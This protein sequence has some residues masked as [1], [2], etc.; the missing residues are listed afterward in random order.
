MSEL[1][2]LSLL[3]SLIFSEI[4]GLSPGGVIVPF[5]FVLYLDDPV[6]L[7]ATVLSALG[8]LCA[9]K[10]LS[11][12]TILYG[13]RRFAVYLLVGLL[14]K[15]LFT[16]VYFGNSY[17]FYHLSMTIG[18][19]VPGILGREMERQGIWKTLAALASVVLAARLLQI[20]LGQVAL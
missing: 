13:R 12:Y 8:A 10:F 7:A 4:T 2:I 9:V 11:R 20:L 15:A 5:Y 14:E 6:K 1:A 16:Y 17:M 19:L 18:Y 3:L